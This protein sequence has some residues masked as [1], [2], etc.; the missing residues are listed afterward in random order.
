MRKL[1]TV[2]TVDEVF[3]I[4]G[5][6][7]IEGIR[8]GGWKLVTQK[9]NNFAV[10]TP[11]VYFEI[12]SLL[13]LNDP[14]FE[15]LANK[16]VR[17]NA[18]GIDC[19][20]L[21]TIKLRGCVSQGLALPMSEFPEIA[22]DVLATFEKEDAIAILQDMSFDEILGVTKYEPEIPAQLSGQIKGNFPSF[23][24]K[25]DQERWQNISQ[26]DWDLVKDDQFEI[27]EKLD[28]SSMTVYLNDGVFGVCSRNLD[29]KETE[30]NSF[31]QIARK[32]DLERK[33]RELGM[34]I[35]IQGELVGPGVQKNPNKLTELDFFV[36]D[37]F[38]VDAQDYFGPPDRL[39]VTSQ[40]GLNHVPILSVATTLPDFQQFATIADG[41]GVLGAKARE[42]LV[43]KSHVR[44]FSFKIIS[45]TYL[46][47]HDTD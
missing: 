33:M 6:D 43:Y 9:S 1:V 7:Q 32:Y 44:D 15:F 12:D 42:G 21:K 11:V 40:L 17:K 41:A 2:R 34:N 35:L 16:G 14:R 19:H 45:N 4:E 38:N 3:P 13:P 10:G 37:I 8:L 26:K 22:Q 30:G 28:G 5:A 29:L 23:G 24:R 20:R 36:F 39:S 27:T 18:A 47:K 25:T 46:L 31:W